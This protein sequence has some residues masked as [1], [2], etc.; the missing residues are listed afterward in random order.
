MSVKKIILSLFILVVTGVILFSV[1][2][3]QNVDVIIKKTIETIGTQTTKTQVKLQAVNVSLRSGRGEL[4][5]L[6]VNN[7]KGYST[8]YAFLMDQ[9]ALQVDPSSLLDDVI[10]INEITIDGVKIIAQQQDLNHLN[11]Y[12]LLKSIR[13]STPAPRAKNPDPQIK[14]NVRIM[15]EKV[16]LTNNNIKL[17]S[18]QL[19]EQSIDFPA[20]NLT[21]IGDKQTGLPPHELAKAILSPLLAQA[22]GAVKAKLKELASEKGKDKLKQW[23]DDKLDDKQKKQVGK[24]KSLFGK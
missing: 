23:V 5:G 12:A 24:L 19:G 13:E 16:T 2:A 10:V 1:I 22:S 6:Q 3:L 11:L 18:E 9:I 15:V 8:D 14:N 20:I 4:L 21:N 17:I 7:P